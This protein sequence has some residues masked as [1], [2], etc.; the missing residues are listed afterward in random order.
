MYEVED[1]Q[2][3]ENGRKVVEVREDGRGWKM[4]E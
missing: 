2:V 3:D 1:G 4:L